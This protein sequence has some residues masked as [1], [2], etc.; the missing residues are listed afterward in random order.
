LHE[1]KNALRLQVQ[2]NQVCEQRLEA[3]Y[4]ISHQVRVCDTL[5][6]L[7]PSIHKIIRQ[8]LD[9]TNM[10]VALLNEQD[11][12]LAFPYY[13]DEKHFGEKREDGMSG[14]KSGPLA[15]GL[16]EHVLTTGEALVADLPTRRQLM[17]EHDVYQDS[18]TGALRDYGEEYLWV[19]VP[20]KLKGK[21]VGVLALQYYQ[22][23]Q[24][25]SPQDLDWLNFS[26]EQIALALRSTSYS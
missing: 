26:A 10:C 13:V 4:Q 18:C 24:Q 3:L 6:A 5:D 12:T 16:T 25:F 23:G 1:A 11:N 19:G 21:A 22:Q 14:F 9:A 7:L 20:V 8:Q 17:D 2:A 15:T